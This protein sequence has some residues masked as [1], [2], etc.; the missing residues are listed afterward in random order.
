L[1][2]RRYGSLNCNLPM[3][4][5]C[6]LLDGAPATRGVGEGCIRRKTRGGDGVATME[7]V[8]EVGYVLGII[9]YC[10]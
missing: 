1:R 7:G 4:L 9:V 6:N 2:R 10:R 8:D 3:L 5:G